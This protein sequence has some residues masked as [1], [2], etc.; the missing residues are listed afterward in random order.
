MERKTLVVIGGGAA[1][2]FCAVNAA[3]QAPQLTVMVLEQSNQ[4]L[5]KVRISGGGRCNLTHQ[6]E[7][8]AELVKA[9]PRGASWLKKSF[10][11]FF[12]Q[13]T[14]QWFE[15]RGVALKVEEDGRMFPVSDRSE[16]VIEALMRDL[17]AYGVQVHFQS[18]VLQ[19]RS[20][21]AVPESS[22]APRFEIET[23]A[24]KSF[25]ADYLC[26]ACGGFPKLDMFS[27]I[28]QLG[29]TIQAPVPSLFTFNMPQERIR[30]LMG[31]SVP[32]AVV[33]IEGSK[34][35]STGPLLITHWGM[36]GPAIL[37]L[38]AWGARELADQQYRF[39][40]LVQWTAKDES[41]VRLM[42]QEHRQVHGAQQVAT[43]NPLQLPQR[44]WQFLLEEAVIDPLQKWAE[45]PAKKQNLL[46][47]L[48]SQHRFS[49]TG[50]TTFKEEFVTAGGV[51]LQEVDSYTMMSK[52]HPHLYFAGE[53]LDVD[54]IT[55]GYNFQHAWTSGYLSAAAIVRATQTTLK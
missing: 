20:L 49:V 8:V 3:R 37:K 1:G 52:I 36:S 4:L 43:R 46:I 6:E 54:G 11:H 2:I 23:L 28:Q 47:Q 42:I 51:S 13:D 29:H 9:Y 45:L 24:G 27:W 38:S 33:K 26:I 5:S 21:S 41:A 15:T 35:R 22:Q 7:S 17:N 16:S 48:L 39:T 14:I 50:K 19:I 18:K 34:L 25:T 32:Q 53:I 55:G 44:L 30:T 40:A 10:R 12:T 31:L